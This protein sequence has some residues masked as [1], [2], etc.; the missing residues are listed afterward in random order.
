MLNWFIN[1]PTCVQPGGHTGARYNVHY[2]RWAYDQYRTALNEMASQNDWIYVDL[3]DYLPASRF[4][5][6]IFHRT[7]EGEQRL[8]QKL[9]EIILA[10]SCRQ[11]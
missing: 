7:P 5:N 9:A 4:S 3:W 10:Q 2:P 8:A 6:S 11:P 1:E